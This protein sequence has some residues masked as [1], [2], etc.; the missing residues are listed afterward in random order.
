MKLLEFSVA[1]FKN[2]RTK[3]TLDQLGPINVIHGPNNVGKSNLLQAMGLFFRC[4]EGVLLEEPMPL[5]PYHLRGLELQSR[6][7]FH[8][9][10]PT[11]VRLEA[12]LEVVQE[13]LTKA[14][15]G[16]SLPAGEVDLALE[17]IWNGDHTLRHVRRFRFAN[18]FDAIQQKLGETEKE[19]VLRFAR[20]LAKN[21]PVQEGPN[22]QFAIIGVRRDLEL[23]QVSREGSDPAPLALEMYDCRESLDTARRDRWLAFVEAMQEFTDITGDGVFEVTFQRREDKARLVF[24]T[25]EARI[26]LRLLGT[27]VQQVAALLGHMLLSNGSIVA[28]EE[29]EL[30]LRWDLQDKLR[31]VFE[32]LVTERPRRGPSQIFLSSHSPAF[33]WGDDFY[34]M[35]PG[36]DGPSVTRRPVSAAKLAVGCD[37]PHAGLPED[38]SQAYISSQGVVKVPEYIR[39]ALG[40]VGG[41][42]VVFLEEENEVHLLSNAQFL[43]R[44]GAVDDDDEH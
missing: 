43:Q 25:P 39:A 17:L 16:Q 41:G 13:E 1:G 36:K 19:D 42:G 18:G 26:P 14:G 6:H 24:D 33:E 27:G 10:A 23:D 35:E 28:I 15:I 5:Q 21:F 29:P 7:I 20:S 9:E 8:L 22:Q 32:R 34:S 4:L 11:K 37:P 38:A 3:V 30:N 12:K 44:L 31:R 40:L 2:I